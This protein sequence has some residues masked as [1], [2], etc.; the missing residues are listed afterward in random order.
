[1]KSKKQTIRRNLL[2]STL[3]LPSKEVDSTRSGFKR[4]L[5]L[6]LLDEQC[7]ASAEEE[8]ITE[9]P[10]KKLKNTTDITKFKLKSL[11]VCLGD[12]KLVKSAKK[13]TSKAQIESKSP[14]KCV[15]FSLN[16]HYPFENAEIQPIK[17]LRKQK[18]LLKSVR[19]PISRSTDKLIKQKYRKRNDFNENVIPETNN[20]KKRSLRFLR[21]EIGRQKSKNMFKNR[22]D[23][24][25]ERVKRKYVRKADKLAAS[26]QNELN[27][28]QVEAAKLPD[29]PEIDFFQQ[30]KLIIYQIFT[31]KISFI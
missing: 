2:N 6:P 22:R 15:L 20:L 29:K 23:N 27:E 21:T 9:S 11:T 28:P 7:P 25:V 31:E 4:R 5:S 17:P 12:R 30:G 14:R 24:F 13:T 3:G 8:T 19:K 16:E 26:N 10:R 1:M 18:I